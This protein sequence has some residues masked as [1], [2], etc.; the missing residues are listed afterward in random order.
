MKTA[1][2]PA[3]P[4]TVRPLAP[5]D[6]DA[7]LADVL[8]GLAAAESLLE[9]SAQ[10]PLLALVAWGDAPLGALR[11]AFTASGYRISALHALP[12]A[13]PRVVPALVADVR[14]R[15]PG[16]RLEARAGVAPG[17]Q[18]LHEA[19]L[20]AGFEALHEKI[21]FR[22]SLVGYEPPEPDPFTY[23][24]Y[25]DTGRAALREVVTR[26]FPV[27]PLAVAWTDPLEVLD[28]ILHRAEGEGELDTSLW[29]LA[30]FQGRLAG[31][32]LLLRSGAV[33]TLGYVALVPDL[34]GR[35]LGRLLHMHAL[36]ALARSGAQRYE[37]RTT[38]D[39]PAM[40]RVFR[41]NGCKRHGASRVYRLHRA[42]G[43]LHLASF[44][45]LVATLRAQDYACEVREEGAWVHVPA[46]FGAAE[47]TLDLGWMADADV[48]QVGH[49]SPLPIPHGL[50]ARLATAI[51]EANAGL[52]VPGFFLDDRA[53]TLGFRAAIPFERSGEV[54]V[55]RLRGMMETV[56]RTVALHEASWRRLAGP[57][58]APSL[59]ERVPV[60][61]A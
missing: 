23:R 6:L 10:H 52:R 34:Q 29:R 17:D 3:P 43:P 60:R 28:N 5:A 9:A 7:G 2:V 50:R 33:G 44:A 61:P 27:S 37:D 39:N 31:V 13:L 11:G 1:P 14:R 57:A 41:S 15:F 26:V 16:Q 38:D 58:G 12:A 42:P 25:G 54:A 32:A 55:A 40:L 45:E 22:R 49:T 21:Q 48:L 24:P 36:A 4:L 47:A 51:C 46:R 56:V 8:P 19:L 53:R 20:H 18:P 59:L 30:Y 35:G